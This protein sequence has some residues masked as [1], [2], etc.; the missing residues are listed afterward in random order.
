MGRSAAEQRRLLGDYHHEIDL[1]AA[2]TRDF[3][4]ASGSAHGGG[5]ARATPIFFTWP[6]ATDAGS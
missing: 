5:V 4:R 1:A 6:R 2:A 3:P